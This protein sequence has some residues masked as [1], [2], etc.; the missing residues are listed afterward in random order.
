MDLAQE[1]APYIG[2]FK[3]G[4][5]LHTIASVE[6]VDII[7]YVSLVGGSS[8]LDLKFHDTPGTVYGASK[9]CCV[10]GVYMF[11]I[12]VANESMCKRAVEG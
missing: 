10:P 2:S 1:L 5:E 4:K 12:H 8:F 3:I 9:A 11:N 6:A 7:K